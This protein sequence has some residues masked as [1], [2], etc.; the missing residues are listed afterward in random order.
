[1]TNLVIF[2]RAGKLQQP[3]DKSK[4]HDTGALAPQDLFPPLVVASNLGTLI[5]Q[6]ILARVAFHVKRH[7]LCRA[8]KIIESE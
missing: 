4:N 6:N 5:H 2:K 3:W 8:G 1:M 7:R